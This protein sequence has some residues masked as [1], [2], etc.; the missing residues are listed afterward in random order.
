MKKLLKILKYTLLGFMSLVIVLAVITFFY[1]RQPQFG[2][3]PSGERLTRVE[4][5]PHYK[6]G[7][8]VNKV[9]KPIITE[10][11]S[12]I[13]ESY[14]TIFAKNPRVA[15]KDSLPSVQTDLKHLPPDS[16]VLVWFGH[17]SVFIQV[18]GK[19][20]LIDPIFSGNAS[21]IPGS[22]K[23]YKGS[24]TYHAAD[25]PEIDYLLISHD[26]YDHLDYETVVALQQKVKH[27]I[28]GLGVGADFEYWGYKPSQIIEQDWDKDVNVAPGFV[29]H[30]VSSQ[31]DS[32][33]G[34]VR[35]KSLW[36]SYLVIAPNMKI[37]ISGDGGHD[38]RFKQL[39][40]QYGP[41]DWAILECGQYNKAWQSV[42][43]LPE[44]V[45]QSALE[46]HARN[47]LPIHHSKFTLAQHDWDEPLIKISELSKNQPYRLATP[48]IGEVVQLN[49]TKQTFTQWWKGIK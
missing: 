46:M 4:R 36:M 23:A 3:T 48:L 42:H 16:N 41:I 44:E 18:A 33:R 17:S 35:A 27:V 12:V 29:I 5:S 28:C 30:T 6:D 9:E 1:M 40:K 20:I 24:N 43:Q 11:Y 26:H 34:F 19:R 7:H 25:M 22:L 49:S 32:G 15:P 13:G 2:K 21:P 37:Y 8:F 10:G 14:K 39:G 31:H 47:L 38:D 45:M